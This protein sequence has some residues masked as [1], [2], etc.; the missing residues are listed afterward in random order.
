MRTLKQNLSKTEALAWSRRLIDEGTNLEND[1]QKFMNE[2]QDFR[3]SGAWALLGHENFSSW[4]R[5]AAPMM[6]MTYGRLSGL[7]YKNYDKK[8]IEYNIKRKKARYVQIRQMKSGVLFIEAEA[9]LAMRK[10]VK[11][12]RGFHSGNLAINEVI[13]QIAYFYLDAPPEVCKM[14]A[15]KQRHHLLESKKQKGWGYTIP[16]H[17]SRSKHRGPYSV[18]KEQ[19][20][21]EAKCS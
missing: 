1:R 18:S 2:I 16:E 7:A 9:E 3:M 13:A 11:R 5:Y 20:E 8:R 21:V 17:K 12:W 10:A 15:N 6:H 4:I 19:L 14:F